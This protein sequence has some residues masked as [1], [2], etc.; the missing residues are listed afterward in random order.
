MIM[1]LISRRKFRSTLG[2]WL[3]QSYEDCHLSKN[4]FE[5]YIRDIKFL[6]HKYRYNA[7]AGD[8][9]GCGELEFHDAF[10]YFPK[11]S[12]GA[13]GSNAKNGLLDYS[14]ADPVKGIA[15]SYD[16]L[17]LKTTR[18]LLY[19]QYEELIW[20]HEKRTTDDMVMM[21]MMVYCIHLSKLINAAGQFTF[22]GERLISDGNVEYD[23]DG[24]KVVHAVPFR[25]ASSLS[26]ISSLRLIEKVCRLIEK[27]R[28]K[29]GGLTASGTK[30]IKIAIL[31]KFNDDIENE[32]YIERFIKDGYSTDLFGEYSIEFTYF[33]PKELT[34]FAINVTAKTKDGEDLF[35]NLLDRDFYLQKCKNYDMICLLDMGC[36]Y[37]DTNTFS[38]AYGD[39]PYEALKSRFGSYDFLS[40][41]DGNNVDNI[42]YR[43]YDGL[44]SATIK[45]IEHH[46]YGKNHSFEFDSRLFYTLNSLK[47]DLGS[48]SVYLFLSHDRGQTISSSLQHR[49][50]CKGE[51]YN[52]REVTAYDW[53]DRN[54]LSLDDR[55]VRI[56]EI[57]SDEFSKMNIIPVRLWKV[58]KSMGDYFYTEDFVNLFSI[59]SSE[60]SE[61]DTEKYSHSFKKPDFDFIKYA[62]DTKIYIDYS[63]LKK[64][65]LSFCIESPLN[66]SNENNEKY[67]LYKDIA[68]QFVYNL[69]KLALDSRCYE[70]CSSGYCRSVLVNA[71]I[72][73]SIG[74]EHLLVAKKLQ[75]KTYFSGDMDVAIRELKDRINIEELNHSIEPFDVYTKRQKDNLTLC[76]AIDFINRSEYKRT[77]YLAEKLEPYIR[78]LVN[79]TDS[80]QIQ[81]FALRIIQNG[82]QICEK[83]GYSDCGLYKC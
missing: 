34:P 12:I 42:S 47:D 57:F 21:L 45:W 18:L 65:R 83:I 77:T 28:A 3:R 46:F 50:L 51:Y 48:R 67:L 40:Q 56:S 24:N 26:K 14:I 9:Y 41:R 73:D 6:I 7:F 36:F 25:M 30:C 78:S 29:N 76:S 54:V 71:M 1:V 80:K 79:E 52:G 59:E 22:A 37:T 63:E 32:T 55:K 39:S 49:N 81:V 68:E 15:F 74:L 72:S 60:S 23:E 64:D 2:Q 44:Y 82:K 61:S 13:S 70:D 8:K 43:V 20:K 5:N 27:L 4:Y 69:M 10:G 35:G 38:D 75:N 33:S 66:E 16:S 58:V 62:M 11:K 19:K 31:G 17:N 53:S